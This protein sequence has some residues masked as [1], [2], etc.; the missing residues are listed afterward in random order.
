MSGNNREVL[1]FNRRIITAMISISGTAKIHKAVT[2]LKIGF[3]DCETSI[4]NQE[5]PKPKNKDPESPIKIFLFDKLNT[6]K[7]DNITR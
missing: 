5:I 7:A 6:R 4:S 2:G 1:F 3:S